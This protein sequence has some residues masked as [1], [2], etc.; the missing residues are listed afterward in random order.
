MTFMDATHSRQ[1]WRAEGISAL[2]QSRVVRV[3]CDMQGSQ[4][5]KANL[6]EVASTA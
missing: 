3:I 2:G 1:V 6:L 5:M 4:D